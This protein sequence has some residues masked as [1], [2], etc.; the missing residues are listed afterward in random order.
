MA[1]NLCSAGQLKKPIGFH[2]DFDRFFDDV[3]SNRQW[4]PTRGGLTPTSFKPKVDVLNNEQAYTVLAELPGLSSD[5]VEITIEKEI[6]TLKGEKKKI[7]EDE[8]KKGTL[9]VE[10]SYGS[11]QRRFSLPAEVD[12]DKISAKFENGVL[13]INLPKSVEAMKKEEVKKIAIG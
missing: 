1:R 6:L 9:Y 5:D 13:S 2:R 7:H 11:F 12:R 3:F 8:D 10:R 4:A